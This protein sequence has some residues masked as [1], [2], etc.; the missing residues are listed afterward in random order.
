[1]RSLPSGGCDR[2]QGVG[3]VPW[4]SQAADICGFLLTEYQTIRCEQA[5]ALITAYTDIGERTCDR[6]LIVS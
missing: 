2:S 4:A 6:P 3:K 1:M 5:G